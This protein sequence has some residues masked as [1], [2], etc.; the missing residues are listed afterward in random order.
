MRTV[1]SVIGTRP[2]AIKMAPV[3]K[4]L[5]QHEECVRSVVCS[6]GQHREMLDQVLGLFAIAPAYELN[7]MQVN[8]G[9]AQQT[10]RLVD[11]LDDV[12]EELHPHCQLADGDTTTIL[13]TS[14]VSTYRCIPLRHL[15]P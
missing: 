1:L 5:A 2:E 9:L 14:L 4:E 6:T 3:I 15:M 10:A 11:R 13:T 7:L 12:L 8:Q